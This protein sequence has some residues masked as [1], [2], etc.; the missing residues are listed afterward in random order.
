MVV[1]AAL[2]GTASAWPVL[3]TALQVGRILAVPVRAV[4]VQAAGGAV[5]EYLADS[6]V[7]LYVE[8]GDVVHRLVAADVAAVVIGARA[9]KDARSLGGTAAGV[10]AAIDKPLVVVPPDADPGAVVRRVLVPLDGTVD[11]SL[12]ARPW[13]D[14]ALDAGTEVTVVHVIEPESPLTFTG[15]GRG[16]VETVTRAGPAGEVISAVAWEYGSELIV[17]GWSGGL[18]P[19]RARTVHSVLAKSPVPVILA[20]VPVIVCPD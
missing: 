6:G 15:W 12:A 14:R 19:G 1:L 5:P 18:D 3:A 4:H 20:P 13:V 10:A 16:P 9:K 7:P 11:G 2:D 17:L 8:R